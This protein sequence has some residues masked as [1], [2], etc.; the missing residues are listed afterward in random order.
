MIRSTISQ[1]IEDYLKT[2]YVLT[3]ENPLAS[4]SLIAT[5]LGVTSASV[6]GMLIKLS[7]TD[8]PLIKYQRHHG[9]ALTPTGE[10]VALEILRYHRLTEMFLHQVLEYPLDAVH[11]EA[12]RLEHVIS[13][14]FVERIDKTLGRPS[15]DP[16]G[17]PIPD[18][19]LS[20][21][22]VSSTHL[23]ELRPGQSAKVVRVENSNAE[24]LRY[25]SQLGLTPSTELLV[26]DF[27]PFESNLTF[28]IKG[29]PGP[30]TLDLAVTSQVYVDVIR[31]D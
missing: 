17:D 27:S 25:L 14:D 12:D 3:R 4:T 21:P 2:I 28:Q 29:Q 26:I 30:V 5:A 7:E 11:D 22:A 16:H 10:R 31:L 23:S 24:L 19:E 18:R 15:H 8:P 1:P 9:A 13:A 20:L 6:T